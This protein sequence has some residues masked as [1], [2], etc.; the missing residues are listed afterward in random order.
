MAPNNR[1]PNV[2]GG[3][4]AAPVGS[5]TSRRVLL[6]DD[7]PFFLAMAQNLLRPGGYKVQTASNG[8]E[9]LQVARTT[10]PDVILLDVEMPG[11]DGFETCR[12]LKADPATAEIPIVM[13]TAST[14]RKLTQK[15]F[16]A[17]AAA[18][19]LKSMGEARLLGVVQMVLTTKQVR[20]AGP[21]SS[22]DP[23]PADP[24]SVGTRAP[25]E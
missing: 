23:A 24:A 5:A 3:P 9:A 12:R 21:Q 6:V 10:R 18:A 11:M 13:L 19:L 14:D 22:A 25:G 2:P 8:R 4:G 15:A 1:P 17:G 20:P 16:Q 7:Q